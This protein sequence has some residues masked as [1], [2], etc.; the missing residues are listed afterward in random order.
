MIRNIFDAYGI[1]DVFIIE[2]EQSASVGH[3]RWSNSTKRRV[4][5]HPPTEIV[6]YRDWHLETRFRRDRF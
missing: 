2:I 6:F 1:G 4:G 5:G 3:K